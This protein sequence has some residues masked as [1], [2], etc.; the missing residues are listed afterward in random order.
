L[1]RVKPEKNRVGIKVKPRKR[2]T[3]AAVFMGFVIVVSVYYVA[4][5]Q[6]QN[7]TASSGAIQFKAAIVDQLSLTFPNQTF[8]D[9]ATS[10]LKRVGYTVDYYPGE[11]VTVEFYRNVQRS[12][13]R[14]IIFRVHTTGHGA[15][16][17]SE[18][19]S[20]SSH[21]WEQLKEQLWKVSY[22]GNPPFYFGI[23]PSFVKSCM[24]GRFNETVILAMGCTT[25]QFDDM[26][27]AFIE[28]GARVYV[29]WTGTVSASHTD[30]A[31]THLLQ[32]L[33]LDKQPI[34]SAISQTVNEVGP[35]PLSKAGSTLDFLPEESWDYTIQ[36]P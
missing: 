1:F 10:I 31:T 36:T 5:S 6:S 22:D 26:A 14:I 7:E 32:H 33:L 23:P 18:D 3:A 25:L 20:T 34:M 24:N 30:T 19:Y 9:S 8:I 28:K 16:F 4:W 12:G 17:T 15:F 29:G 27:N 2:N 35:E 13:Y 21:V 11:N